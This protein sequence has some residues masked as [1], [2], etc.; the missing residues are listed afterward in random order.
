MSSLSNKRW[1]GKAVVVG[2]SNPQRQGIRSCQ[3]NN[4]KNFQKTSNLDFHQDPTRFENLLRDVHSQKPILQFD[5]NQHFSSNHIVENFSLKVKEFLTDH[6]EVESTKSH[7]LVKIDDDGFVS[8]GNVNGLA[9]TKTSTAQHNVGLQIGFNSSKFLFH[10]NTEVVSGQRKF[11]TIRSIADGQL[12]AYFEY[13]RVSDQEKWELNTSNRKSERPQTPGSDGMHEFFDFVLWLGLIFAIG[14][15]KSENNEDTS[16]ITG[17]VKEGSD[18]IQSSLK[19]IRNMECSENPDRGDFYYFPHDYECTFPPIVKQLLQI[20]ADE[21]RYRNCFARHIYFSL[22]CTGIM[23]INVSDCCKRHDIAL[24]CA[25]DIPQAIAADTEVITCIIGGIFNY[26]MSTG[27]SGLCGFIDPPFLIANLA[28][29]LVAGLSGALLAWTAHDPKM[30]GEGKFKDSCLCSPN[31]KPT[32][33]CDQPCVNMCDV[34]GS[35][36]TCTRCK[37]ECKYDEYGRL[38]RR[39]FV[40]D[41]ERLPCCEN[42]N[43]YDNV[44]KE[45]CIKEPPCPFTRCY[46]C[47]YKCLSCT[48][49][50]GKH[51]CNDK[52]AKY[53][54]VLDRVEH[55]PCCFGTPGKMPSPSMCETSSDET[56]VFSFRR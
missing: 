10:V 30:F 15:G 14:N 52:R 50:A 16:P 34:T 56:S 21:G 26:A 41:D 2:T 31:G 28:A 37:Y 17:G 51:I 25:K 6:Q 45:D 22:P 48:N 12:I 38:I 19:C 53:K 5:R 23:R 49:W 3:L 35:K 54:I 7:S 46:T 27:I 32:F 20:Y 36:Q 47:S 18:A 11:T 42:T 44:K 29:R 55:L 33:S 1:F 24:W 4:F 8:I 40:K 43:Y 39:N 9:M 13:L